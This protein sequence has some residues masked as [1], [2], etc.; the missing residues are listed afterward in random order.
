[1]MSRMSVLT[2]ILPTACPMD[3]P[4]TC[5]L[6]VEVQDGRVQAIRGSHANPTTAGFICSKV[7]H[8]TKRLYS[9]DRIL[10]PMRRIGAKTSG[11][12][13]RITWQ[14]AMEVIS[15]RFHSIRKEFGA[16]AMLPFYYGGSNGLLGQETS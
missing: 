12:F 13:E 5:S 3:C 1:M 11:K 8:F 6:E 16:E 2:K 14:E 7:A 9:A 4:D 10:Y 15:S